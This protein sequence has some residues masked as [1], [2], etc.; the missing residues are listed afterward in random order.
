MS[1]SAFLQRELDKA[2]AACPSDEKRLRLLAVEAGNW[3][4][5]RI[6]FCVFGEQPFGA[7]H[8]EYGP[9]QASD[10]IVVLGSIQSAQETVKARMAQ[11]EVEHAS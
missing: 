9:M 8:P 4:Q 11:R 10:F 7:P 5:R 3:M 6:R 1:I 2:V